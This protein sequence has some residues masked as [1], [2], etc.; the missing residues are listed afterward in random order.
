L[1]AQLGQSR[2]Q[3]ASTNEA[4]ALAKSQLTGSEAQAQTLGSEIEALQR[5]RTGLRADIATLTQQFDVLSAKVSGADE[6]RETQTRLARQAILQSNLRAE[7]STLVSKNELASSALSETQEELRARNDD[8]VAL[9]KEL[10]ALVSDAP[11]RIATQ[12]PSLR[13][14]TARG[15][16]ATENE[17]LLTSALESAVTPA[18]DATLRDL[19]GQSS[20]FVPRDAQLVGAALG[21]APGLSSLSS[22][23]MTDLQTRIEAGECLTDAL[24]ASTGTINRHTL[25]VLLRSFPLCS[26]G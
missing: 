21:K 11:E 4:L 23:Q 8:L 6:L 12:L 1:N 18:T 13:A 17:E 20:A 3:L 2:A 22:A 24:K 7:L 19:A 14:Q 26:N 15:Q 10:A 5:T 16:D 25:A 9:R